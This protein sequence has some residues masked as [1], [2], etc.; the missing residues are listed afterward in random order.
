[1]AVVQN[2]VFLSG[3]FS[4]IISFFF[5]DSQFLGGHFVPIGYIFTFI[6]CLFLEQLIFALFWRNNVAFRYMCI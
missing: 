5:I 1:M 3:S 2:A 4:E 6:D